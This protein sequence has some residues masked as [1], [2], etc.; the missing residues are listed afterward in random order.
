[1]VPTSEEGLA[2]RAAYFGDGV[3]R[4]SRDLDQCNDLNVTRGSLLRSCDCA[5]IEMSGKD[6]HSTIDLLRHAKPMQRLTRNPYQKPSREWQHGARRNRTEAMWC[7]CAAS[8]K[9]TEQ[10]TANSQKSEQANIDSLDGRSKLPIESLRVDGGGGCQ[11]YGNVPGTPFA[12]ESSYRYVVGRLA[13]ILE[14]LNGRVTLLEKTFETN[15]KT[16]QT[17]MLDRMNTCQNRGM[18]DVVTRRSTP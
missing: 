15:A 9:D 3:V 18:P 6:W 1:M 8:F 5:G 4:I 14:E 13:P 2:M 10:Q 12:I 17:S 7:R 16:A 11:G